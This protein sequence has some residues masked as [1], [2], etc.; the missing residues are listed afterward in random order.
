MKTSLSPHGLLSS[1]TQ[2]ILS[3]VN[4]VAC[5]SVYRGPND[6]DNHELSTHCHWPTSREP[7]GLGEMAAVPQWALQRLTWTLEQD[8]DDIHVSMG[9]Q[10][11][12]YL[13]I[14]GLLVLLRHLVIHWRVVVPGNER[15]ILL[16]VDVKRLQAIKHACIVDAPHS[17]CPCCQW[18]RLSGLCSHQALIMMMLSSVHLC[19]PMCHNQ[20]ACHHQDADSCHNADTMRQRR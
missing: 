17:F 3:A 7:Q 2:T 13:A 19:L 5:S 9:M 18:A 11:W 15:G 1:P 8:C 20:V 12:R 14:V 4:L 10:P 6:G 16:T